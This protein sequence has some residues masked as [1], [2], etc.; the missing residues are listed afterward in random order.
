[1]T[2]KR[3]RTTVT[4]SAATASVD[5]GLGAPYGRV[6]K[7]ELKGDDANV[8]NNT[9]FAFSDAEDRILLAATAFDAGTD[10]SSVKMTS[11]DFSTV[12]VGFYLAPVESDVVDSGGDPSANTEGNVPGVVAKSPLTIDLAAGT[13]TDVFEITVFV[14]V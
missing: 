9:T 6:F 7:V 12:G 3:R 1:M 14:E 2:I 5:L 8:D 11:Q 13:A 10:D 4:M